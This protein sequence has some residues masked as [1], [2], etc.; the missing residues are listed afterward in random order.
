MVR[1][2]FMTNH[3]FYIFNNLVC[4]CYADDDIFNPGPS[5]SFRKRSGS[6]FPTD[7][8]TSLSISEGTVVLNTDRALTLANNEKLCVTPHFAQVVKATDQ[9]LV[10]HLNLIAPVP[11]KVVPDP[12]N[13]QGHSVEGDMSRLM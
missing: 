3:F 5:A 9:G 4:Y 6:P 1:P 12:D 7:E 2:S 10:V 11:F 8:P 13:V